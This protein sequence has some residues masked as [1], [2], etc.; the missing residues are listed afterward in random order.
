MERIVTCKRLFGGTID[1]P[2][3]K[4]AFRPGAYALVMRQGMLLMMRVRPTGEWFLPG[5]GIEPGEP[6]EEALLREVM[7]ETGLEVTVR[8][9]FC[10]RENFFHYDPDARAF[11]GLC[12]FFLCEP[13]SDEPL[14]ALAGNDPEEG[15]PAWIDPASLREDQYHGLAYEVVREFLAARGG[16]R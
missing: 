6:V 10:F 13:V 3:S 1:V 9:F 2:A 4:L 12:F 8:S 7:E 5:G 14:P 11:H 15:D 16:D